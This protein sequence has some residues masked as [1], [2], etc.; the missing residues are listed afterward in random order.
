V[1]I[2]TKAGSSEATGCC[3]YLD[4]SDLG[5]VECPVDEHAP[6]GP[7][8]KQGANHSLT[9][10]EAAHHTSHNET[11]APFG[12]PS[13]FDLTPYKERVKA[14]LADPKWAK[15]MGC[16]LI[17]SAASLCKVALGAPEPPVTD[18]AASA[19]DA[20]LANSGR[21]H[22]IAALQVISQQ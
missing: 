10:G 6:E 19:S 16:D 17:P 5:G 14:A 3:G 1:G 21:R 4:L 20:R 7:S 15:V 22:L 13:R 18:F 11:I 2:T 9:R 12:L 8:V